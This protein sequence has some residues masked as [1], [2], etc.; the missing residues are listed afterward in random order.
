MKE[1]GLYP[2]KIFG[3]SRIVWKWRRMLANMKT[4]TRTTMEFYPLP[5]N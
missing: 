3:V 4:R 2:S 1:V 5:F